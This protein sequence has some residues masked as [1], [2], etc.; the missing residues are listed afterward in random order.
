M[1]ERLATCSGGLSPVRG[2]EA[3]C[4]PG[5]KLSP[6]GDADKNS[7]RFIGPRNSRS[8]LR[9]G[10]LKHRARVADV[11]RVPRVATAARILR[12]EIRPLAVVI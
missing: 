8:A 4:T 11:E 3:P 9:H 7:F 2:R 6:S 10:R 1:S 5:L 12:T